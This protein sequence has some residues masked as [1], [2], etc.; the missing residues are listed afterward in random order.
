[1]APLRRFPLLTGG[2]TSFGTVHRGIHLSPGDRFARSTGSLDGADEGPSPTGGNFRST[3]VRSSSPCRTHRSMRMVH[4]QEQRRTP[5][6]KVL[7]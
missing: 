5:Q 6:D 2:S 7:W 3:V 4:N 1:M